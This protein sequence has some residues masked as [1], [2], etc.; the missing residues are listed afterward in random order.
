MLP[1]P[2]ERRFQTGRRLIDNS[3]AQKPIHAEN[4]WQACN[5]LP[6]SQALRCGDG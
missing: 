1:F 2:E 3:L 4:A 5:N 6:Y